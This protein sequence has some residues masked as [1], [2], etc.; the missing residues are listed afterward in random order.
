MTEISW[1]QRMAMLEESN[2]T[3]EY[4]QLQAQIDEINEKLKQ[5]EILDTKE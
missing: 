1:A 2:K 3:M 5:L 4:F